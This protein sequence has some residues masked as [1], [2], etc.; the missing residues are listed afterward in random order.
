MTHPESITLTAS[1]INDSAIAPLWRRGAAFITDWLVL[2]AIGC[3]L[4]LL[5]QEQFQ[6]MGPWGRLVGFGIALAYFGIMDS[7]IYQ[8]R[9]LGKWALR[10]RVVAHDGASLTVPKALLRAAVFCIPIF[11]NNATLGA[12]IDD[13][14]LPVLQTLLVFGLGGA[15]L[16]LLVAN[17]RTRQSVH[18]LMVGALVVC[19]ETRTVPPSLPLWRGHLV[20]IAVWCGMVSCMMLLTIP[21]LSSRY[22][23][24]MAQVEAQ[25]SRLPEVHMA[26]ISLNTTY[27]NGSLASQVLQ[28]TASLRAP[29]TDDQALAKK[30]AVLALQ[31]YPQGRPLTFIS[32][33]L[34]SGYDIGIWSYRRSWTLKGSPDYWDGNSR[35]H[36]IN[37]VVPAR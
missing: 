8:G 37:L 34:T 33:S 21:V 29:V 11:L 27:T 1:P 17:R 6:A 3:L 10:I 16:Y 23:S 18:D 2:I 9:T 13:V 15:I 24:G 4:G 5:F 7:H 31:T 12:K 20:A 36:S 30:I 14:A 35:S 19:S 26:G 25:V 28:I 32:V 22:F